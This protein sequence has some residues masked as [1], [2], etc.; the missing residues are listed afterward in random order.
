MKKTPTKSGITRKGFRV[1]HFPRPLGSW[2]LE[3]NTASTKGEAE[4]FKSHDIMISSKNEKPYNIPWKQG[5]FYVFSIFDG[6]MIY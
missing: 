5:I 3:K 6:I 4:I 1:S 2:K